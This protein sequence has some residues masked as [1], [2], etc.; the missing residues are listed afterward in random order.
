MKSHVWNLWGKKFVIDGSVEPTGRGIQVGEWEYRVHVQD[1]GE[2]KPVREDV[3]V[4]VL[5]SFLRRADAS[6][7]QALLEQRVAP[8]VR[9]M[10]EVVKKQFGG[11]DAEA[12]AY[13]L[14]V[15]CSQNKGLLESGTLRVL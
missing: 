7:K 11:R 8:Q 15:T 3:A 9:E 13:A 5:L 10:I 14:C 2:W 1:E 12:N 4:G 6:L